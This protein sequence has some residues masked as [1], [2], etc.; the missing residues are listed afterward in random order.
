M[1]SE[2]PSPPPP[3]PEEDLPP[4]P[5]PPP[6][7]VEPPEPPPLPPPPPPVSTLPKASVTSKDNDEVKEPGAAPDS[8]TRKRQFSPSAQEPVSQSIPTEQGSRTQSTMDSSKSST[9]TDHDIKA[10]VSTGSP[11]S[12][13]PL[14]A[15]Q[16][17]KTTFVG[18]ASGEKRVKFLR[19]MGLGKTTAIQ[20]KPDSPE[21][22]SRD[23][24]RRQ[25]QSADMERQY[26]QGRRRRHRF[27]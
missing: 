20:A 9:S 27:N 8:G 11:K 1:L 7:P 12:N 14:S 4:P 21:E 5:P 23:A 24:A 17:E 25:E 2:Q 16:W 19:L 15:N 10:K 26:E 3:P 18:D 6:P 13:T 22:A